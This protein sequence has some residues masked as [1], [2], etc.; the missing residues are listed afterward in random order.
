MAQY[1]HEEIET[2]LMAM[3]AWVGNASAASRYLQSE[4]QLTISPGTLNNWKQI[5]AIRYD[6]LR[7]KYAAQMESQIAHE[8]RDVA[9]L[10][11]DVQRLALQRASERLEAG[12]DDD[13]SRSAANAARVS[14]SNIDKLLSL[15]GRPTQITETRN[16]GEILRSLAAKGVIAIPET[17]ET[18]ETAGTPEVP[19][20][21]EVADG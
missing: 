6:E 18:A 7:E 20:L 19:A 11:T 5:H 14:Q 16:L 10:A 4:K 17:A 8:L 15:T 12:E 1:S 21:P 13:P 9:R 3:I 2:G